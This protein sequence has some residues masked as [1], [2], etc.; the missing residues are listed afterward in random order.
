MKTHLLFFGLAV[1]LLA[2]GGFIAY[3]TDRYEAVL[4]AMV[5]AA[6]CVFL[7]FYFRKNKVRLLFVPREPEAKP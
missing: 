5:G 7:A 3:T 6:M 2:L 4:Y 1:V